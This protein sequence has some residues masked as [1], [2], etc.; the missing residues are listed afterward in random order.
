MADLGNVAGLNPRGVQI[1][2]E[3]WEEHHR[4]VAEAGMTA[5][6]ESWSGSDTDW[7]W[8]DTTQ[9]EVRDYGTLLWT[10]PARVQERFGGADDEAGDQQITLHRYMVSIPHDATV[11]GWVHVVESGD[12][13]LDWLKVVDIL[14]G[15]IRWQRDLMCT[16][17]LG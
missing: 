10:G 7:V 5:V 6:V 9:S 1:I 13:L 3:R 17:H 15:S 2:P 8:D 12:L 16:D 11:G 4:P 14:K